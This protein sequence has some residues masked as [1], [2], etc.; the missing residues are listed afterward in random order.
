MSRL[1]PDGVR[2]AWRVAQNPPAG[3]GFP[4]PFVIDW[5]DSAHPSE[6]APAGVT[7]VRIAAV[8]PDPDSLR[9]AL[10]ALGVEVTVVEG[11]EPALAA[12]LDTPGGR[13]ELR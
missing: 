12:I 3:P 10:E 4:V 7:L 13:V 1:R 6:S 2:L 8:H 11:P 5:L 9:P